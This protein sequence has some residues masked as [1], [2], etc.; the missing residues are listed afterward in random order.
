MARGEIEI[1]K[2]RPLFTPP[3]VVLVTAGDNIIAIG[4]FHTFSFRPLLVGIG[5]MPK[6][7]SHALIKESGEF[8]VCFPTREL[9]EAVEYCGTHSG[10]DVDKFEGTGLTRMSG[11]AIEAPLIGECPL[12]LECKVVRELEL[13]GTH[14]WFVGEVV[15]AHGREELDAEEML[16]YW[17]KVYRVPGEVVYRR[18]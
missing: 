13:G 3:P 5:V 17:N 10:R 4:L 16:I 8:G 18:G 9:A 2:V 7:H 12:C 6:R 11:K 1:S 15:A 14:T